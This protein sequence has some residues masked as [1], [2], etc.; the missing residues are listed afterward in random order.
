[1]NGS[2]ELRRAGTVKHS[3]MHESRMSK[4]PR[5]CIRIKPCNKSGKSGENS[6]YSASNLPPPIERKRPRSSWK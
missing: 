1:M 4:G 6:L 5:A 3:S 2:S